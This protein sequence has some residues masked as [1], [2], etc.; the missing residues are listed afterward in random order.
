MMKVAIDGTPLAVPTGGITRYTVQ[1][2]QALAAEFPED[3]FEL[4]PGQPGRWWSQGLRKALYR[5]DFSLF[6]GTDFAVPY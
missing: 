6:H 3:H 4:L 2:H 5:G 1:L